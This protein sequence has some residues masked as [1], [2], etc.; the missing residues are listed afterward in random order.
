[1]MNQKKTKKSFLGLVA[2]GLGMGAADVVPGVSGGTIAFITGIYEEFLATI[3][4]LKFSLFKTWKNEGFKAMW[5]QINGRFLIALFLGIGI[6]I[7][8]LAKLL[9]HLLETQAV[10][11]WSFFFGLILA[12]I[13]LVGKTVEKWNLQNILGLIGGAAIAFI[14][15]ILA[16]SAGNESLLYIFLCGMLAIC[17]MILPGISGSF[18][19]LLL[20]AYTTILGSITGVLDGVKIKDWAAVA[21]NGLIVF[22]FICGCII[23]LISF[24]RLLNYL[25]KKS[26]NFIIAILTGFLIGSL[27]KIWPWKETT[28]WGIDRHGEKVAVVQKNI[29]PTNFDHLFGESQLVLAILLTFAGL[30]LIFCLAYFGKHKEPIQA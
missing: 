4:G 17:A 21:E 7:L 24:S 19:L 30:A 16:P 20:G 27:N 25:F 29:S 13:W 1:M 26:K 10:L 5:E 8:S 23:G 18:I 22:I 3:S 14:I 11:L 9:D 6:S 2:R 15:T 28:Q 12:S